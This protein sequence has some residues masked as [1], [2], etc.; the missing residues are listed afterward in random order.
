LARSAGSSPFQEFGAGPQNQLHGQPDRRKQS[1]EQAPPILIS[2]LRL[3]QSTPTQHR[4]AESSLMPD[5]VVRTGTI[6]FITWS[7]GHLRPS[8]TFDFLTSIAG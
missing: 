8:L 7:H 1:K 2:K 5:L 6:V 4:P 3:H